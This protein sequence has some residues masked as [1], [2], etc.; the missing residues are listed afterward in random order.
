MNLHRT[1]VEAEWKHIR[2][3]DH[4]GHQKAAHLSKGLF[5]LANLVSVAGLVITDSGLRDIAHKKYV[6]GCLKM[7]G[8]RAC[9]LADGYIADKTGTKSRTGELVDAT[10]DK[11]EIARG[12]QILSS[13]GIIPRDVALSFAVQNVSNT[14]SSFVAKKRGIEIHPS[15]AGKITTFGQWETLTS[16]CIQAALDTRPIADQSEQRI[17]ES[18]ADISA[19]ATSAL[20]AMA[21]LEYVK[22]AFGPAPEAAS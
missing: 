11:F 19:A 4:N 12:I 14:I 7:V 6:S 15:A 21:S 13:A 22:T 9:D 5:T 1:D 20:G 8:G 2:H 3:E 10:I 16:Y 18:I 17:V